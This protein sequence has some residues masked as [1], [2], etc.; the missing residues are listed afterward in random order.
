[1]SR[2]NDYPSTFQYSPS[3]QIMV[4]KCLSSSK[5]TSLGEMTNYRFGAE[6]NIYKP[7]TF[8]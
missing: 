4:S 2:N 1:M 5:K 3:T 6:K 7:E 8:S